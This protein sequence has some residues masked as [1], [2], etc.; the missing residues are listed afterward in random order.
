MGSFNWGTQIAKITASV[1]L[2]LTWGFFSKK[3][4]W[5]GHLKL[6]KFMCE[7][8]LLLLFLGES[9]KLKKQIKVEDGLF[10]RNL[11]FKMWL[12]TQKYRRAHYL[13]LAKLS[14][15]V[16]LV[17]LNETLQCWWYRICPIDSKKFFKYVVWELQWIQL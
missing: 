16:K 1:I 17:S 15:L 4:S 10:I 6:T 3:S 13:I 12:A 11:Q 8:N 7:M 14:L 9:R 2:Q 5:N